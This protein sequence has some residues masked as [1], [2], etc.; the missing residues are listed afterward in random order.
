MSNSSG[1]TIRRCLTQSQPAFN[2]ILIL[3]FMGQQNTS[4]PGMRTL[5]TDVAEHHIT[6]MTVNYIMLNATVTEIE[7][8]KRVCLIE[9]STAFILLCL[10][11]QVQYS[12]VIGQK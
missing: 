9:V 6:L 4:I 3:I 12:T 1:N 2:L 5:K 11:S 7:S 10:H 8:F